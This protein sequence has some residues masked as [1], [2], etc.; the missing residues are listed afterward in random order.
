MNWKGL[1]R[2]LRDF[3]VKMG[4]R[5]GCSRES[6]LGRVNIRKLREYVVFFGRGSIDLFDS[7]LF[8]GQ[9]G[10]YEDLKSLNEDIK[11][12]NFPIN[13]KLRCSM[14]NMLHKVPFLTFLIPK[15]FS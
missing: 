11:R 13:H 10:N 3:M 12:L 1:S 7:P 4:V 2:V 6:I 15:F 8:L 5:E 14:E 9:M